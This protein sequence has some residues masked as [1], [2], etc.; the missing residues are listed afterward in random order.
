MAS[1]RDRRT[2]PSASQIMFGKVY[3]PLI[4]KR[5]Y[6]QFG[7]SYTTYETDRNTWRAT[8]LYS[9][10]IEKEIILATKTFIRCELEKYN[11]KLPE[12]LDF[13]KAFITNI[14]DYLS[15]YTMKNPE[16]PGRT[17]KKA[18][19]ALMDTLWGK[20]DYIQMLLIRQEVQ[21]VRRQRTFGMGARQKQ[22]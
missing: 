9:A 17:R 16:F 6:T 5:V 18:K 7:A 19:A 11:K 1:N 4:C 2:K 20:F 22:Y 14:V 15:A 8:I 12:N 21:A 10:E 3:V 13:L